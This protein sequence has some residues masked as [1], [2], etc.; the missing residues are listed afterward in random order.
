M[1]RFI[2]KLSTTLL[3]FTLLTNQVAPTFTYAQEISEPTTVET[4]NTETTE[5]PAVETTVSTENT[6]SEANEAT[7]TGAL[8]VNAQIGQVKVTATN[9]T[10][11]DAQYTTKNR[12]GDV[13]L[14]G[15]KVANPIIGG[16]IEFT[17]PTEYIESFTVATGGPVKSVDN[18][19]PGLLKVYL[20]DITQTTTASFPFTFKFKDRVTPEGYTFSPKI[21]LKDSTGNTLKEV[22]DSLIYKVKVDKQ[23]LFK[24][25]GT[26]TTQAYTI[27]NRE[28][29]GG[30]ATGEAITKAS[31]VT[32]QFSLSTNTLGGGQTQNWGNGKAQTRAAKTITITDTLPTYEK[33]DGTTGTAVFDPAKNPGWTLN[34]D[35]TVSKTITGSDTLN[36]TNSEAELALREERLV[37]SFPNAKTKTNIVNN[38]KTELTFIQH[39][40][41]EPKLTVSD[42]IQFKLIGQL[43]SDS[44]F[45]KSNNDKQTLNVDAGAPDTSVAT[46]ILGFTNTSPSTISKLTLVDE[47]LDENECI[48]T[49]SVLL[50]PMHHLI[51]MYMG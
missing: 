33:A 4:S 35:S 41:S 14:D 24:Y 11:S 37:L 18:S 40:E 25:N 47:D 51:W 22:T 13:Q 9:S 2:H 45:R 44:S 7:A 12:Q 19:T 36:D 31:D 29:Y 38:A 39:G 42:D 46:W 3:I 1:K 21:V 34:A 23:S 48:S 15:S 43:I 17:Y 27:N 32:F 8:G 49:Q 50:F 10:G 16:Y 28:I 5:T 30:K 20:S 26:N 6:T